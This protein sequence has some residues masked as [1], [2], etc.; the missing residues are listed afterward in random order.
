MLLSENWEAH[1]TGSSTKFDGCGGAEIVH[2]KP[3]HSAALL[4]AR[5]KYE[6]R[7]EGPPFK[8][9]LSAAGKDLKGMPCH[10][11]PSSLHIRKKFDGASPSFSAAFESELEMLRTYRK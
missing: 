10:L 9:V 8:E 6:A 1:V 3:G 11:S 5:R 7:F 2:R 4:L